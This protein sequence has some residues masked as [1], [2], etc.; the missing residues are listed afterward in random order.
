[1]KSGQQEAGARLN[2]EI[3]ISKDMS[4]VV[5]GNLCSTGMPSLCTQ[6]LV[7]RAAKE[8]AATYVMISLGLS[9]AILRFGQRISPMDILR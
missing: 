8:E 5:V 9:K 2:T 1:M 6:M 4:L 7:R 3:H